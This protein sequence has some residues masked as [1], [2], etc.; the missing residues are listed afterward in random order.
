MKKNFILINLLIISS[1]LFSQTNEN[2]SA[3]LF[4]TVSILAS[5]SL[6][7]RESGTVGGEKAAMFIANQMKMIGLKPLADNSTS[8]FDRF[9]MNYPVRFR[10]SKL[11]INSVA[12]EYPSEFGATDL[13]ASGAV[14]G[15]LI[16]VKSGEIDALSGIDDYNKKDVKGKIVL[17]DIFNNQIV[18][19]NTLALKSIEKRVKL[20]ESNG[21]IG[22]LL[23][24]SSRKDIEDVLFGSPFTDSVAIP[25]VYIA[26]TAFRKLKKLDRANCSMSVEI[27][28]TSSR[29][30]NVVGMVDNKSDK[31]VVVG[32]HYDHLGMT[33]YKEDGNYLAYNGADDNASGTAVLLELA[34]WVANNESLKYNYIFVAFAAEE[35]GLF[36]SKAFA[37]AEII[38]SDKIAY[39]LNMDMV[40]R[41]GCQGDTISVLGVGTSEA[42]RPILETLDSPDFHIKKVQGAPPFSDH[43]PFVKKRIPVIYFTTGIHKQYHT[44]ADDTEL[45]NFQGMV[46]LTTY[47]RNFLR[48]AERVSEI[49]FDKLNFLQQSRAYISVF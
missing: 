33:G 37:N 25:V 5:D 28:R 1:I 13:S 11:S 4:K 35:K 39:M 14:N 23:Y 10:Q 31:T 18:T 36:G 21:A 46:E 17:L 15:E 12:F 49:K 40:G 27:H 2:S 45:I 3:R 43:A 6:Q 29:P 34:R 26:R 22:V 24:N 32:A 19:E 30:A 20:A 38:N 42:W 16:D 41:L 44:P 7:G 47:L 9:T 48:E 8:Y